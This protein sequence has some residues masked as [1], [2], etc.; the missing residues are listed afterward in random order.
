MNNRL[1]MV[2]PSQFYPLIRLI[3]AAR[4]VI[5]DTNRLSIRIQQLLRN[6][7]CGNSFHYPSE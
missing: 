1:S 5:V 4:I 3:F 6:D 2:L 7:R